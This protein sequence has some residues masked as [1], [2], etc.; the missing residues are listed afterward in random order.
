MNDEAAKLRR[1]LERYRLRLQSITD[2]RTAR[3]LRALMAQ[4]EMRLREIGTDKSGSR[5]GTQL[6]STAIGLDVPL[7]TD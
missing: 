7:P 4:M 6:R 1:E 3:V 2:L 5:A